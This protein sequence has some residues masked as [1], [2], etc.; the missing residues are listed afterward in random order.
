MRDDKYDA[1]EVGSEVI[2]T[3]A[4]QEGAMG[5]MASNIQPIGGNHPIR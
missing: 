1:L 5:P 4:D 3:L 2:Y